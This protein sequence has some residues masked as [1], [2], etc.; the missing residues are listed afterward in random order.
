MLTL[1]LLRASWTSWSDEG[2]ESVA[3]ARAGT[4]RSETV[5]MEMVSGSWCGAAQGG[6]GVASSMRT[7]YAHAA[8]SLG[9]RGHQRSCVR[10]RQGQSRVA[11]GRRQ[12]DSRG[13]GRKGELLARGRD[14]FD[15]ARKDEDDGR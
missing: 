11:A 14:V 6:D 2:A 1:M 13:T 4:R 9:C 15:A 3:G 10:G 8:P 12:T 7:S 5:A